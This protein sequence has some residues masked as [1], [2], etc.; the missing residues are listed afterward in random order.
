[1]RRT[2]TSLAALGFALGTP[3]LAQDADHTEVQDRLSAAGFEAPRI[4]DEVEVARVTGE[5]GNTFFV[6]GGLDWMAGG[7][8]TT[9]M[10]TG[11]G[12][13]TDATT[14]GATGTEPAG[15]LTGQVQQ[16]Q[17]TDPTA[18]GTGTGTDT[19]VAADP[20]APDTGTDTAADPLA[21]DTG[22]DTAA[23]PLAPDTG[24][25]T[26]ADPLAPDTATDTGVAA[27]PAAPAGQDGMMAGGMG[28]SLED[29][30]SE[31]GFDDYEIL[32]EARVAEVLVGEGD[33]QTIF[34]ITG[35]EDAAE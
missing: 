35:I 1:M 14:L 25:D 13:G 33:G 29:Q 3:A 24:T 27:D 8:G 31:A 20:L 23:D 16:Q 7:I 12:T 9:G 10:G 4:L 32:G 19:G 11:V 6:I 22:T 28:M 2:L 26:A 18:P 17:A 34:V 21:P 30:L 5:D 15:D